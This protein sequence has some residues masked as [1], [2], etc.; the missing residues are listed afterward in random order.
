LWRQTKE[1]DL[2]SGE[3]AIPLRSASLLNLEVL[4]VY[5]IIYS[6]VDEKPEIAWK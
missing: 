1:N 5:K 6:A 2:E 3:D 4:T